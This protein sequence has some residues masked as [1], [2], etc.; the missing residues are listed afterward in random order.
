MTSVATQLSA[1]F[2]TNIT[3]P[4][5]GSIISG[6]NATALQLA[7]SINPNIVCNTCFFAA[8]EVVDLVVPAVGQTPVAT[9]LK[10]FGATVPALGQ[11]TIDQ[12]FDWTCA[13]KPLALSTSKPPLPK[14]MGFPLT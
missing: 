11:T 14:H 3:V 10:I 7:T 4:F 5:L 2:G 12:L 13:Y 8:L 9:V 1:Y 6:Q